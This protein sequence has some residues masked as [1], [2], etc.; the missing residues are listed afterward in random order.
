MQSLRGNF[1]LFIFNYVDK[2]TVT[3]L[4]FCITIREKNAKKALSVNSECVEALIELSKINDARGRKKKGIKTI[5]KALL[6]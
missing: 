3:I 5:K 2:C 1:L 4:V 6:F